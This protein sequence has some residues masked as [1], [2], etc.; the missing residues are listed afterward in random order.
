MLFYNLCDKPRRYSALA[1]KNIEVN[2]IFL[3]RL[4]LSL[5]YKCKERFSRKACVNFV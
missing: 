5:Y 4:L 2:F 3:A 1:L